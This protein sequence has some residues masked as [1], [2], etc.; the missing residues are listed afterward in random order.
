MGGPPQKRKYFVFF[1]LGRGRPGIPNNVKAN[2]NGTVNGATLTKGRDNVSNTAY[3][4]GGTLAT[5]IQNVSDNHYIN[6]GTGML[7]GDGE[8]SIMMWINTTSSAQSH[9]LQKRDSSINGEYI[10]ELKNNGKIRFWTYYY[11][12]KWTVTSSSAVNDGSW[13]HL[14]LVQKNNGGQ[15]YLDGS[16]DQTDNSGG[17]VNLGLTLKTYMG[18]DLRDY[19]RY[20]SGKVDDFRIYSRALSASEIQTLYAIID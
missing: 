8:F 7:S 20:Y 19:N 4:F 14:V 16:L 11:G 15:M 3:L 12:Y 9:I 1:I 17:K 5:G 6:F 18:G 10:V 13:H 2:Y